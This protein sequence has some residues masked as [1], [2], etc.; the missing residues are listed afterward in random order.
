MK[1]SD[2][3][4]MQLG[5]LG[6]SILLM[7]VFGCSVG[8]E[9]ETNSQD[10]EV[11]EGLTIADGQMDLLEQSG[12]PLEDFKAIFSLGWKEI[13]VPMLLTAETAGHA[14]AVAF[15]QPISQQ[16]RPFNGGIDMGSVFINYQT[17]QLEMRKLVS[18]VG[19]V[20]YSLG[21]R[22]RPGIVNN[23]EYIP[24]ITYE[25]EV[26]GSANFDPLQIDL[27]S[28]PALLSINS[29]SIG[30][31]ISAASDLTL[32]WTGG[33]ADS[34]VVIHIHPARFRPIGV[35]P[36]PGQMPVPGQRPPQGGPGH[37]GLMPPPPPISPNSIIVVLDDNP[38]SYTIS[39]SDLQNLINQTSAQGII[40]GVSQMDLQEID[41]NGEQVRAVLHNGDRVGLIFE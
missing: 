20:V 26:T 28:P 6:I 33:N 11:S 16:P 15:E 24:N 1:G 12:H 40:C 34:G 39:A 23:L 17:N 8:N 35:R 3:K 7:I 32:D 13:F 18:P 21:H 5:F 38:G 30:D 29:H 14:F 41:H 37:R 4:I 10:S 27:T 2:M 36:A 19:G 9:P 31:T 25:F 22:P